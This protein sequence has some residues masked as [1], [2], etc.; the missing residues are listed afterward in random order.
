MYGY[1]CFSFSGFLRFNSTSQDLQP[2]GPFFRWPSV[3]EGN[4]RGP[5]HRGGTLWVLETL[6]KADSGGVLAT[7]VVPT[8]PASSALHSVQ[9]G[10][11]PVSPSDLSLF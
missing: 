4:P 8:G 6:R 11:H 3:T 1:G 5:A 10:L 7:S 9:T 2:P